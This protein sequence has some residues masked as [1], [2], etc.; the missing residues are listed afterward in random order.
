VDDGALMPGSEVRVGSRAHP[1]EGLLRG[2]G[3]MLGYLH[4]V[5]NDEAYEGEWF[6][7]GDLVEVADDR[8]T[9]VGR[10]KEIVNR[11]GFKI[12]LNEIDAA[13]VEFPGLK[14][15]AGFGLPDRETGEHLAVAV[16]P[17]DGVDVTLGDLLD[18]LRAGGLSTRKL[19]EEVVVWDEAL[20]RTASGKVVRSRLTMD[21]SSKRSMCVER[22]QT[23]AHSPSAGS[24]PSTE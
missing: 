22:L 21:A 14:E 4:E 16:V 18:H 13:L 5:D 11:N 3:V 15:W 9:V 8:L 17:E 10:L 12:S 23:G 2:P 6:R 24:S 19:P 1:Q 7:S 20:P